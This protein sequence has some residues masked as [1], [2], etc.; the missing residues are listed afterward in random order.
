MRLFFALQVVSPWP[1]RL[2]PGRFIAEEHRHLTLAFLGESNMPDLESFPKPPFSIGLSGFF[3]KLV[4]LPK[5]VHPHVAAWHI[6]WLEGEQ[7]LNAYQKQVLQ[8]LKLNES[9]FL[10]HVTIAREPFDKEAWE[11]QFELLPM[12]VKDV[13]LCELLGYSQY[14]TIW[15]YPLQAPFEEHEHTADIAFVIRGDLYLHAQ[16]AL[17]FKFPPFLPYI[18]SRKLTTVNEIVTALNEIIAKIDSKIGCPLKAVS[19]HGEIENGEW[20]MIVDV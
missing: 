7:I 19:L 11:H 20:E 2:P 8:F 12:Y 17:S 10:P 5:H 1:D 15:A 3:D 13:R 9:P 4:L 18:D 14:R 6:H 16:L